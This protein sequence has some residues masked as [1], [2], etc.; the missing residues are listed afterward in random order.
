MAAYVDPINIPLNEISNTNKVF[1]LHFLTG[2]VHK[3]NTILLQD[4]VLKA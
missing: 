4:L 3:T 1:F 2:E